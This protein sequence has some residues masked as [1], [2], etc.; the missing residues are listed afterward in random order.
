MLFHNIVINI[1]ALVASI[2]CCVA[3]LT[4]CFTPLHAVPVGDVLG[5]P[6]MRKEEHRFRCARF[7][8]TRPCSKYRADSLDLDRWKSMQSWAR[9]REGV[10]MD[11]RFG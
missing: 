3:H 9:Q 6:D 5:Q 10:L 2:G 11:L 4:R 7:Q 1:F 8:G